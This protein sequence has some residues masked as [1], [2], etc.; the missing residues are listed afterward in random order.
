VEDPTTFDSLV[1]N[2]AGVEPEAAMIG[3]TC[4]S[5]RI[6]APPAPVAAGWVSAEHTVSGSRAAIKVLK[7]TQPQQQHLVKR[8]RRGPRGEPRRRS[9]H[10]HGAR[11]RWHPSGAAYLVMEYLTG[12]RSRA[13]SAPPPVAP[14]QALARSASARS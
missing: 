13:T 6:I 1:K 14:A 4:G 5:Y 12:E 11:F 9:R 10:R 2:V 3:E 8:F 7:P